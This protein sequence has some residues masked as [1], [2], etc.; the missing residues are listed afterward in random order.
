MILER[1]N[2][3][4]SHGVP[5]AY[6]ITKDEN[7]FAVRT[8]TINNHCRT[9]QEWY[10]LDDISEYFCKFKEVELPDELDDRLNELISKRRW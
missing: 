3:V 9:L 10:D 2:S 5:C 1:I 4:N 7:G 8:M 6:V